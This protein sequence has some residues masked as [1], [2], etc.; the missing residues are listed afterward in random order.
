M[1]NQSFA[2]DP[3]GLR[4]LLGVNTITTMKPGQYSSLN[5]VDSFNPLTVLKE[6]SAIMQFFK[7]SQDFFGY[8]PYEI[9]QVSGVDQ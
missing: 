5:Q 4:D 6:E 7:S 2:V 8:I 9:T 1:N 3:N